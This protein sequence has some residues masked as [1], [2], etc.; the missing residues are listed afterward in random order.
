MGYRTYIGKISKENHLNLKDLSLK[1]LYEKYEIDDPEIDHLNVSKLIDSILY[2]FGKASDFDD[3]K[4]YTPFFDNKETHNYYN[5][6]NEIWI[7][8]RDYLKHIINYYNNKIKDNYN[9]MLTPFFGEKYDPCDFLN[10]IE[11][12]YNS[13]RFDFNFD[14]SKITQEQQNALWEILEHIRWFRIE[15]TQLTP[16]NLDDGNERITKSWKIEYGIFDLVRIYKTFNW[17]NDL[18]IY[19]GW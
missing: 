8:N 7:V 10:T 18:L 2:E 4:Y 12:K 6:D 19:Y 1:E 9:E 16:F 14:F 15:W 11:S 17:E 3:E 13:D 5:T